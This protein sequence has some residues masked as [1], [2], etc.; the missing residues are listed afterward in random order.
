[1][2]Q[3]DLIA[4]FLENNKGFVARYCAGFDDTNRTTQAPSL[5]NHAAWNLG[6]I[7][8]T[9]HRVRAM[10]DSQP[11]PTEDFI[12]GADR[13]DATRFGTGAVAFG[14]AP[15]ADPAAYPSWARCRAIFDASI[16]RLAAAVRSASDAK[17]AEVV[18]WGPLKMPLGILAM[19]MAVHNGMHTGQLAD[20]RRALGFKSVFS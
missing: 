2:R 6:H 11:L 17:L 5:P 16:D 15:T 12:E 13:G 8:L 10:V 4:D 3:Q 19:R 18:E 20:L 1:M 14:S 9:M 7:A